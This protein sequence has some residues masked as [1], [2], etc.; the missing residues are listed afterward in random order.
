MQTIILYK[1]QPIGDKSPKDIEILIKGSFPTFE[2]ISKSDKLFNDEAVSLETTLHNTLPGG[3]YDRLLQKMLERRAS[4][5]VV[6]FGR[7]E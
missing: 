5:F 2:T 7:G 1:A 4:H 3:T 6:P